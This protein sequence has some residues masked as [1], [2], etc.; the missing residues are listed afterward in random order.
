M[1]PVVWRPTS[2]SYHF[3]FLCLCELFFLLLFL[4]RGDWT[5]HIAGRSQGLNETVQEIEFGLTLNS[6][7]SLNA[8]FESSCIVAL[9]TADTTGWWFS[10]SISW[11]SLAHSNR[12]YIIALPRFASTCSCIL[13]IINCLVS[14][15]LKFNKD[16][17]NS[18]R[19][20]SEHKDRRSL[21]SCIVSV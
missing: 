11:F 14:G 1:D 6:M 21:A 20:R 9:T 5:V 15:E 13:E 18:L 12:V 2:S 10:I 19:L 4:T 7:I 17:I 8:V 16:Q 3:P